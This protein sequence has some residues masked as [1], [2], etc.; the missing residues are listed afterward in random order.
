VY[1]IKDADP[2][3]HRLPNGL[4]EFPLSTTQILGRRIPFGGGGYFRLYPLRITRLL[5]S[6]LNTQGYPAMFYVH[7][8]E[9]GP[10]I[11]K[12]DGLSAYRKFRHYYNCSNGTM[13]L[14]RLL[15]GFK[16]RPAIEVLRKLNLL[17]N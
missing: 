14:K 3:I 2:S 11:P 15:Q 1:G 5:L 17:G 9:V 8:Y 12:I 4:I 10:V 6:R 13:R 7:P 16:F